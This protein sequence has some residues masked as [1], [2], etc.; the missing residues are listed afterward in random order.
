MPS[1][2]TA[3]VCFAKGELGVS[4]IKSV[5]TAKEGFELGPSNQISA[6]LRETNVISF[7]RRLGAL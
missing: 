1:T 6:G 3:F 7:K 5:E 4:S 2:E